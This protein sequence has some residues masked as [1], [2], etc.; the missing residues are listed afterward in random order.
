MSKEEEPKKIN[1]NH[2]NSEPV[3]IPVKKSDAK[4]D[5]LRIL[6]GYEKDVLKPNFKELSKPGKLKKVPI[7]EIYKFRMTKGTQN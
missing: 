3:V 7:T 6:L 4:N 5:A 2:E 1:I